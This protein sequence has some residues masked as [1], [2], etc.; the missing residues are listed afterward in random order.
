LAR[1][2]LTGRD[3]ISVKTEA[4]EAPEVE[5]WAAEEAP[6]AEVAVVPEAEAAEEAAEVEVSAAEVAPEAEVAVVPEAEA[7]EEAAEVEVAPEA[8]EAPEEAPPVPPPPQEPSHARATV[9]VVRATPTAT[10]KILAPVIAVSTEHAS[11]KCFP[12]VALP[13][14]SAMT[15][16]R[17]PTI[18]AI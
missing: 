15:I 14:F 17:A 9:N 5:A 6:E 2:L 12:I 16:T 4:E 10:I 1:L 13:I 8:E 7:V 11:T 3:S 18:A